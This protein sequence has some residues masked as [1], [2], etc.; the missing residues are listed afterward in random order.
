MVGSSNLSRRSNVSCRYSE[1][2]SH[3]GLKVR[4]Y[5]FD[6]YCP[7]HLTH[8][9]GICHLVMTC[10]FDPQKTSSILVSLT[11]ALCNSM[12]EYCADN[13]VTQVRFLL[14]GP[15]KNIM[16]FS[17]TAMY[18]RKYLFNIRC[19]YACARLT[20]YRELQKFVLSK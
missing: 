1:D 15:F 11:H 8:L 17:S 6:S 20:A 12:V 14:E 18:H 19:K 4:R 7:H 5:R 16:T 13:A 2:G 10:G 9:L 3:D